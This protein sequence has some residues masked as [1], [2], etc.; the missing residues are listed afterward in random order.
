M[1]SENT[2]VFHIGFARN[3]LSQVVLRNPKTFYS[4]AQIYRG[5]KL[6]ID[7]LIKSISQESDEYV[8]ELQ[9]F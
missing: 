7:E 5:E 2:T 9:I 3:A 6:F 8:L 4:S 1:N